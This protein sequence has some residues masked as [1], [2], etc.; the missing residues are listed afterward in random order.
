MRGP[1]GMFNIE[2]MAAGRAE[3][4]AERVAVVLEA[5][6]LEKSWVSSL[7]KETSLFSGTQLQCKLG[8]IQKT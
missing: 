7:K 5:L 6:F 3:F 8:S 4:T 1:S 2:L